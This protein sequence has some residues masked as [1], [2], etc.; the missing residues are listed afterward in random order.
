MIRITAR[1]M[2]A[3]VVLDSA[4]VVVRAAPILRYMLGWHADRVMSYAARKGWQAERLT[5]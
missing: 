1:H 2:C 4:E 3:G 5:S